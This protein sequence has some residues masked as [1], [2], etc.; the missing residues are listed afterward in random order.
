MRTKII[1]ELAQGYEG[2]PRQ[3]LELT[4]AALRSNCD[5]IKFQ[6]LYADE[7]AVPN[8]KHYKFFKKLEMDFKVWQQV[9]KLIKKNKKEMMLNISGFKSYKVAKDLKLNSIKLHT[10]HFFFNDLIDLIKNEFENLYFSIGGIHLQ[11]IEKF[12]KFHGFKK[13]KYHKRINFTYGFQSNPTPINKNNILKLKSLIN[14]FP[15]FNFGFEDHT[16]KDSELKLITP[17]IALPLGVKH[18]EKH[19]TLKNKIIEDFESALDS[20]EFNKFVSYV[21]TFEEALGDG[22]LT[23]NREEIKYRNKM[24]K[25]V[26][27]NKNIDK[28]E[29][30]KKTD[31]SLKRVIDTKKNCI[32]EIEM[33][34][35][36]KIKIKK[37]KFDPILKSDLM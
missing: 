8:Y 20:Q 9:N 31:L 7:T 28:F 1:A 4:K 22:R 21:R 37:K 14:T 18:I 24:L 10:T 25:V 35:G 3:T 17:L 12:I 11:E 19:L 26:V 6:C 2:N 23:L 34:I 15:N 33:V 36:K 27:A 5:V 16:S 29:N 30:L 13:K 32:N